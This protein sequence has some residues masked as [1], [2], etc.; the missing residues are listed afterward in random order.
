MSFRRACGS[1]D[2]SKARTVSFLTRLL[3]PAKPSRAPSSSWAAFHAAVFHRRIILSSSDGLT[4]VT[5]AVVESPPVSS[6][7]QQLIGLTGLRCCLF[8]ATAEKAGVRSSQGENVV[9]RM[10]GFASRL[11]AYPDT[12]YVLI[13]QSNP[14]V[15]SSFLSDRR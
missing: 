7:W 1:P 13:R 14:D 12:T 11:F 4:E 2:S 3:H 6:G 9:L 10:V 15:C 5:S 8:S